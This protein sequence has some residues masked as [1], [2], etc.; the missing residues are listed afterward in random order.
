ML[1]LIYGGDSPDKDS[2]IKNKIGSETEPVWILVPEQFSLSTEKS[3]IKDF[4]ISAQTRIKVITFSRLCNLVLSKL[5]PLRLKYIDGAG[6]Q[7]LAA[8][9][10]RT[11]RKKMKYLGRAM[12]RRGFSSELVNLI[13]EFKRYGVSSQMLT[14]ALSDSN[15]ELSLKLEDIA[16]ILDTFN[17]Y[18]ES[19]A[20]D[21]EDNLPLICPNLHKCDFL[22]GHL[23]I[24]HFRSFTPVE[25]S[26]IGELMK[27]SDITV[28][29]SCD[30]LNSPSIPFEPITA[31]YRRLTKLADDIG[32]E[33]SEPLCIQPCG[34]NSELA[35]LRDNYFAPR[36]APYKTAPAYVNVYELNNPY[37]EAEAAADLILNLCRTEHRKFSDFLILA[38]DTNAYNRIMPSVFESRGIDIFLDTRRSILSK[39][40][41]S[42]ICSALEILA[43]GYSYDRVM[44]MARSGIFDISA[45]DIDTFENYLLAVSPTPADWNKK[46][47]EYAPDGYDIVSINRTRKA[48]CALPDY[49][50]SNLHGRQSADEICTLLLNLLDHP[51][52][53]N[54]IKSICDEFTSKDMPYL[55]DETRQVW[56]SLI[57]V[58]TQISALMD[59]ED[60]SRRDFYDLF[61]S[62][63]GGISV[64]L[65][66]QTQGSVTF[67]QIDRFRNENTPI[68]IVLGLND[69]VFP[70][71]HTSEG[72]ISD[73]ERLKLKDL[74]IVLAPV[75]ESKLSEEQILIYSTLTSASERLYLMYSSTNNDGELTNPSPII[76]R[77]CGRIFPELTVQKPG[78]SNRFGALTS[79]RSAFDSLCSMLSDS[80]GDISALPELGKFMYDYFSD[81]EEYSQKLS[82]ILS[83]LNSPQP[84]K[85][86]KKSVRAIY[87]DKLMLSASKLEKYNACAFAY[88]MQYGL[89]ATERDRGGIKPQNTG[90]IQHDSL[91]YYFYDLQENNRDYMSITQEDCFNKI[92]DLVRENAEKTDSLMYESSSYY[93]YIV[94]RMQSITARTA[95]ETVKFY[96]SSMF[97]P[98]GNELVIDTDGDIPALSIKDAD[99]NEI[100]LLR[101]RV[102]RAD[103][104]VIDGKTYISII[105]YKSS[106]THLDEDL[107]AAGVKLQ[108]LLYSDIICKRLNSTPAAM[109]YMQMT[110]PIINASNLKS[111]SYSEYERLMNKEVSLGGWLNNDSA[112]V[113]AYSKGGE[114][115]E[116]FIPDGTNALVTPEELD[117]RI[118]AANQ[119]ITDSAREIYNGNIKAEPF[120]CGNKYDA[121]QFCPFELSCGKLD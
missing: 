24:L 6:K 26:A 50:I 93:K 105:D 49:L 89:L 68:V 19:Q 33:V 84:D 114:N 87:G 90:T 82:Y 12:Q 30:T 55:A 56:N 8:R 35:H 22:K 100:A 111:D 119:K 71:P 75:L 115:G 11:L 60:I 73:S 91:Y 67:S 18:L 80:K 47:W 66:P 31:T 107:A 77:I 32:I 64:G 98:L 74:G 23:Y 95:W 42:L 120:V 58:I 14:S 25:Y 116:S 40:L 10:I 59:K 85:L 101:G 79:R 108:P 44:S 86:S 1:N 88:F 27:L 46:Q 97:R 102:D 4:G 78:S 39:P 121:C 43:F 5:G 38:R 62:A 21:A 53:Y 52:F 103:T 112:V 36:P 81:T 83:A 118:S 29:L 17:N 45:Y 65:T 63:C 28:S 15:D 51:S 76:K 48:L 110:D 69:G 2:F 16:L 94:S 72:L 57:S 34:T 37:R 70:A 9:T 20:S 3:V 54:R 41:P 117:K 106:E 113:S 61:K 13:S 109:L 99:S 104:A 92:Y 7:I 96:R